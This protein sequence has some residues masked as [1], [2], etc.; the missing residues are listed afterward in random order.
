MGESPGLAN[1][2]AHAIPDPVKTLGLQDKLTRS[3]RVLYPPVGKQRVPVS[4]RPKPDKGA[5][6]ALKEAPA[7]R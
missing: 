2:P 5:G 7:K 4:R 3:G 6:K 1:L